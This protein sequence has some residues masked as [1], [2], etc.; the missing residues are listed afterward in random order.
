M[1]T[2]LLVTLFLSSQTWLNSKGMSISTE[3]C[4]LP[5]GC[6]W[7]TK[8]ETLN[9]FLSCEDF[10][11]DCTFD[12]IAYNRSKKICTGQLGQLD[13]FILT[14]IVNS[15]RHKR[16]VILDNTFNSFQVFRYV[17]FSSSYGYRCY[18]FNLKGF[19]FDLA[20]IP[21]K[22]AI[23]TVSFAFLNTKFQFFDRKGRVL[24]TCRDIQEANLTHQNFIFK[25]DDKPR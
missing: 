17:P 6:R 13:S 2:I 23:F 18:L 21:N 19:Y 25:T 22:E 9:I 14:L 12:P 24:Q 11:P 1:I 15:G 8:K 16:D 3:K 5:K 20:L 4:Y 10:G 7:L